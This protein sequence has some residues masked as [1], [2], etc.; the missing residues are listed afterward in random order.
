MPSIANRKRHPA[1]DQRRNTILRAALDCFVTLGVDATTVGDIRDRSGASVGSIYH[2]FGNKEGVAAAVYAMTLGDYH[3]GLLA[4]VRRARTARALVRGIVHYHVDWTTEHA[5][6]ARF[7]IEM[8]RAESMASKEDDIRAMNRQV[9]S[10]VSDKVQGFVDRG[11][12]VRIPER[13]YG[14]VMIG[15]A[16]ELIRRWLA[17]ERGKLTEADLAAAK[18]PL[19]DAAW[20]ALQSR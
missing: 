1:T 5:D 14:P 12:L 20:A 8:R 2:H 7:L 15:P 11:Q 6:Y 3:D 18:Q 4:C 13:L 9:M 19:A 17:G 10:E 16:Q